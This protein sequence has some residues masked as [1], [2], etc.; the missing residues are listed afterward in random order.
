M[1]KDATPVYWRCD[2]ET[3]YVIDTGTRDT[4]GTDIILTIDKDSKE[5]LEESKLEELLKKIRLFL[6]RYNQPE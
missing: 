5:F 4:V 2:G 3:E 1:H 6:T